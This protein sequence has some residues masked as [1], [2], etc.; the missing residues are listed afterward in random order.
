MAQIDFENIKKIN[1]EKNHI[2]D[3]VSVSYSIFNDKGNKYVQI[4][5]YGKIGR[6][7]PGKI[8]QSFQIDKECAL[9]LINLLK[10]EFEL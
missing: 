6:E 7:F 5:T 9:F 1:K 3:K 2:H 8:S 4:D 10:K